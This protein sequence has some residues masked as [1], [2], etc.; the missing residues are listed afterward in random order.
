MSAKTFKKALKGVSA[1][2]RVTSNLCSAGLHFEQTKKK[3]EASPR[4]DAAVAWSCAASGTKG[5]VT[6]PPC[7]WRPK[8]D[9]FCS[10]STDELQFF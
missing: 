7:M 6:V 2:A 8:G 4:E 9:V 1:L 3:K 10:S 5:V